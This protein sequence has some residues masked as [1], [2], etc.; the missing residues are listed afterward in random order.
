MKLTVGL[1]GFCCQLREVMGLVIWLDRE[2]RQGVSFEGTGPRIELPITRSKVGFKG[3]SVGLYFC[4]FY[5]GLLRR[6]LL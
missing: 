2:F 6:T 5:A 3:W 4:V 1:E